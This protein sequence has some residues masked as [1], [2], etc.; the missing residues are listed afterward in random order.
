MTKSSVVVIGLVVVLV[1]VVGGLVCSGTA[2]DLL[3]PYFTSH[4]EQLRAE[5]GWPDP[6]ASG[7]GGGDAY[8]SAVAGKAWWLALVG[9][10]IVFGFSRLWPGDSNHTGQIAATVGLVLIVC[11]GLTLWTFGFWSVPFLV[12]AALGLW[13]LWITGWPMAKA[14]F[15]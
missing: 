10:L 6:D 12:A 1:L 4:D 7:N 14:F 5:L 11:G 2:G 15:S 9:T 13:D 3:D 8:A